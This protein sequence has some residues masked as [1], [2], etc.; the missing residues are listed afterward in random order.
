[1]WKLNGLFSGKEQ[2]TVERS[3]LVQQ[4][5]ARRTL[6]NRPNDEAVHFSRNMAVDTPDM[7]DQ[8]YRKDYDIAEKCIT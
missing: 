6:A 7:E 2:L 3:V 8:E 4:G 5:F 1:V